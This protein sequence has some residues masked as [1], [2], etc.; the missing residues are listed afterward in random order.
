VEH[1]A[2]IDV[3]LGSAS[4]RVVGAI[5]QIVHEAKM[6]SESRVLIGRFRD[7]GLVLCSCIP[8]LSTIP[9]VQLLQ[10]SGL[11]FRVRRADA[12]DQATNRF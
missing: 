2:R 1:H 12:A 11:A 4:L 3:S 8:R 10:G 5:R 9:A 6:A 7:L